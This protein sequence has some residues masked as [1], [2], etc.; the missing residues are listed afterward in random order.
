MYVCISI[1]EEIDTEYLFTS[2]NEKKNL[3][4]AHTYK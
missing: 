2:D 3:Y 4:G 1:I